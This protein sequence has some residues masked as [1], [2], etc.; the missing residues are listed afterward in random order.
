MPCSKTVIR[1]RIKT[2]TKK[3]ISL[4]RDE[5]KGT[6]LLNVVKDSYPEITKE[7]VRCEQ[8]RDYAK[9]ITDLKEK[10]QIVNQKTPML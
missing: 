2:N 8:V 6:E 4:T 7:D 10:K 5:A 9:L 1:N 3:N